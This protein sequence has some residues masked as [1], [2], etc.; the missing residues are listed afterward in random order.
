M[1]CSNMCGYI[2][3]EIGSCV[4]AF[5]MGCFSKDGTDQKVLDKDQTA[6]GKKPWKQ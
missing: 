2:I 3:T 5:L 4:V 1:H 6:F